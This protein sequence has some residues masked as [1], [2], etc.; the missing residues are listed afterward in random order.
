[1]WAQLVLCPYLFVFGLQMSEFSI[2]ELL[3]Y[4]ALD[5][6]DYERLE[7]YQEKNKIYNYLRYYLVQY[8]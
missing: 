1:M 7:E 8:F 2:E 5:Y 6:H 3:I 4:G